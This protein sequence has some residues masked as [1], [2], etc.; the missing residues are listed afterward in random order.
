MKAVSHILRAR[1]GNIVSVGPDDTVRQALQVMAE[2][3]V[4]AVLVMDE[5]RLSGILSERDYAR[6]IV[7][8]GK[9]SEGTRVREIMSER[10]ICIALDTTL[11]QAMAIMSERSIRHLPVVDGGGQLAGVISIRDLVREIISEQSFV[12]EQLEKYIAT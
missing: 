4:G 5:G 2:A 6:K 7:L 8:K 3:D 10:V 1:K 9:I 12:I 11:E